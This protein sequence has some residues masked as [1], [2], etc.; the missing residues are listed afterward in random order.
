MLA[1]FEVTLLLFLTTVAVAE[2]I[3]LHLIPAQTY[4]ATT[5]HPVP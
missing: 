1:G 3:R 4:A 2:G 5:M